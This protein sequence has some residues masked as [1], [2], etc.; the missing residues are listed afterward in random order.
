[1]R[2]R[3]QLPLQTADLIAGFMAWVI[4]SSLLP[5][6][7]QDIVIPENQL[8][9]LTAVPVVLGSVLRVPFGYLADLLGARV[10]FTA[11]FVLLLAPV[12]L[13]SS[14]TTWQELLVGGVFLGLG[15]AVFSIGVTSLPAY[16]PQERHGFVNGVYGFGNVGTALTTWLA[17]V[18][19]A[20]FGWRAAAQ[21][22]LVL[23][24][25]FAVLNFALGDRSEPRA[26]TP[27]MSQLRAI[28]RDSRLWKFSL[29]YFVTFG[30]F[31]ALTVYLPN[32]LTS[33]Y[34]LDGVTAG[35]ATSAFI[36]TAA[37]VRVLGGWL[38]DR[39]DC[40]RLL[41]GTFAAHIAGAV[42]LAAAP[43]LSLY[44][45]GIYLIGA[46]CGIGNGVVFK[47]V[48]SAF[49]KQADLANGIVSMW[50]GLGGFFPPLVL[51]ASLA[52]FGSYVPGFAAFAL[53]AAACLAIAASMGKRLAPQEPPARGRR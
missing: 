30:A 7:K 15:G 21:L 12:W 4:L 32:F 22:Y 10:M 50:G 49:G 39:F 9:L 1:M 46:A 28:W 48:P 3:I 27:I 40:H 35:I 42:V 51:S 14:A 44:L 19:A 13:I 31:V 53:F 23:L 5:A 34:G 36:V 26:K 29:F 6:I 45:A 16:Y 33:H 8:A 52:A 24:A 11:S 25:A 43:G 38:A 2:A 20:A 41:A 47:L 37:V 18:A 17:P